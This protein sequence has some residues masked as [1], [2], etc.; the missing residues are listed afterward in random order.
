MNTPKVSI[1]IPVHNAGLYLEKC[2]TSLL[3]QTL[4][5]IEV[6]LVLDCP[7]DGSDKLAETYA[8]NDSRIRIIYNDE[9][10]HTGLSRNK[11]IAAATGK[12]IGFHDHDD[13]CETNMY[14]LLYNKAESED[15]DVVRCN[16]TS[17]F[18]TSSGTSKEKY[19]YPAS[20]T[21]LLEKKWLYELVCSDSISC[22][23]WNHLYRASFLKQH[24]IQFLD[25]RTVC[26]EDSIFFLEVY[27]KLNQIGI[28]S[29]YLYYHIFHSSNTGKVYNYRS[30]ANRIT[31]FEELYSF[32]IKN[33]INQEQ[34]Y[35]LLSIN[36]ARSLYSGSRQA[37]LTLP[38]R[39][40]ISEVQQIRKS[41]LAI[42]IIKWLYKRENSQLRSQ[43]KPTITMYLKMVKLIGKK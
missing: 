6:I 14:E 11:G 16:F 24:N 7:T 15:F 36:M 10:L 8:T 42:T 29:D 22:V 43:L 30:I 37:L 20:S 4:T 28:A 40:A 25:S 5:D 9:N 33:E 1:I 39:K 2:L 23:I 12:Y 31:F 13:Y 41:E 26:S 21:N 17:I 18:S 35:A 27:N 34:C 38:L 32:L 19:K 3:N